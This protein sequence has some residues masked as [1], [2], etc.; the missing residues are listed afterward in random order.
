MRDAGWGGDLWLEGGVRPDG[1][2]MRQTFGRGPERRPVRRRETSDAAH[3]GQI[4]QPIGPA[5]SG[6]GLRLGQETE[7]DHGIVQFICARGL[8]PCFVADT[9]DRRFVE[10]AELGSRRRIEPAPA[11]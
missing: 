3:F 4:V 1:F 10:P 8:G 11:R 5:L 6:V 2:D 9:G 7:P